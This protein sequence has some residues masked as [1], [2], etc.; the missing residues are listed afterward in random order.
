MRKTSLLLVALLALHLTSCEEALEDQRVQMPDVR[1]LLALTREAKANLEPSGD[2]HGKLGLADEELRKCQENDRYTPDNVKTVVDALIK[3]SDVDNAL[4]SSLGKAN[5]DLETLEAYRDL[6]KVASENVPVLDEF[7]KELGLLRDEYANAGEKFR[8]TLRDIRS[9]VETS[10]S[11]FESNDLT[12]LESRQQYRGLNDHLKRVDSAW[13]GYLSRHCRIR[14]VTDLF[15]LLI[16]LQILN[17][18]RYWLLGL[19]VLFSGA[20]L[21]FIGLARQGMKFTIRRI[22]GLAAIEEAIGRATELGKSIVYV[23][24]VLDVDDIQ[25]LAGLNILGH[26]ARKTAEYETDLNNPH[27]MPMAL[28][29]AQELVKEACIKAG[30]PDQYRPDMCH[31]LSS[32]PFAYAAGLIGYM[33]REH[34]AAVIYMGTFHSESLLF[35]EVGTQ[36]GAIQIAGT[37]QVSQLPFFVAACDYTLIGEEL[38]AASAYLSNEPILLGTIKGQDA[39]KAFIMAALLIGCLLE[40]LISY[41]C[42]SPSMSTVNYFQ[43]M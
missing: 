37:A 16:H 4:G 24:G 21:Y 18:H 6:G 19:F 35:A 1:A 38:F 17:P 20:I 28:M 40:I 26:V 27:L 23:P 30:K 43:S 7:K 39:G 22:N 14:S 32:D 34:P 9:Y 11:K 25:T 29:S 8:Q 42:L 31:Y 2:F 41:G 12:N 10:I 33:L 15:F 5:S 13:S 3:A 36:I